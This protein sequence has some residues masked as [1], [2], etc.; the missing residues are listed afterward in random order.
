MTTADV[1]VVHAGDEDGVCTACGRRRPAQPA[2]EIVGRHS[3]VPQRSKG[4]LDAKVCTLPQCD[5][6]SSSASPKA[7]G[8]I[9]AA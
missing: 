6:A 4:C 5:L 2:C 8:L 7:V 1:C 3:A 9:A